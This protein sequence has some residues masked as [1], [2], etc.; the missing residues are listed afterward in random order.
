MKIEFAP[1]GLEALEGAEIFNYG[2]LPSAAAYCRRL[3]VVEV[4]NDIVA[5][6][7]ELQPGDMQWLHNHTIFHDRTAF[8]DWAEP[9]RKRH[10]LRLWL[11]VPG[12]RPLPEVYANRYGK[13]DIGDRG[14]IIVPG[15]ALNAPL[16]VV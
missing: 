14:G 7:M 16:D 3:R 10:L 11:A 1:A 5:S 6:Q 15:A 9:E 13:V 2:H 12:A 8:E 4:V